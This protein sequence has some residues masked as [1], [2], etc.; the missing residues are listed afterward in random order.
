MIS[1]IPPKNAPLPDTIRLRNGW[2]M[3]LLMTAA[4]VFFILVAIGFIIAGKGILAF[5]AIFVFLPGIWF[6]VE[7]VR[8]GGSYVLLET[9]QFT[10]GVY[11]AVHSWAWKDVSSFRAET[12]KG[13]R[14]VWCRQ[15]HGDTGDD[16]LI[17]AGSRDPEALADLMNRFRQR[18]IGERFTG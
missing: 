15:E 7:H 1:D 10:R 9:D 4:N 11:G 12:F 3:S 16:I 5:F 13:Q 14:G 17:E 18:A 2:V 6:G 8:T